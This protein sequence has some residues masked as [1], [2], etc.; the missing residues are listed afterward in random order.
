MLLH[1]HLQTKTTDL[2]DFALLLLYDA[3]V[4]TYLHAKILNVPSF[5]KKIKAL[6]VH[7]LNLLFV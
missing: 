5:K 3:H 4:R 2:C 1:S 6:L 7:V